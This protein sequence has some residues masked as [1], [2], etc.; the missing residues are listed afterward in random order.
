[1]TV[2]GDDE[3][4]Q[5]W[6]DFWVEVGAQA[7]TETIRG[8]RVTVPTDLPL[9]VVVRAE[10]L[11]ASTSL[12]DVRELLVDIFAAD[13]LDA[14]TDAGMGALELRTVLAWA[15]AH[16]SGKPIT[17]AEALDVVRGADQG[18]AP[19]PVPPNRA[20]RRATS[21]IG[22]RSKPTSPA[23]TGSHRRASGR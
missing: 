21:R 16:G 17:F 18:E 5:S 7:R 8:V 4:T 14:W 10:Q 1:M 15:S 23:N 20:A 11:A 22:G 19:A 3:S 13:V 12:D 6:D 9:R 2:D